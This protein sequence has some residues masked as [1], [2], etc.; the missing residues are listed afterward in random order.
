MPVA[1]SFKVV[2]SFGVVNDSV[3]SKP[4]LYDGVFVYLSNIK[5]CSSTLT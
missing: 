5:V 2:S 1:L 4:T 3:T